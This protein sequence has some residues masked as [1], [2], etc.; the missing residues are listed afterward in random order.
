MEEFCYSHSFL[1]LTILADPGHSQDSRC[2]TWNCL[3]SWYVLSRRL[4][5]VGKLLDAYFTRKVNRFLHICFLVALCQCQCLLTLVMYEK[6]FKS[7]F[8]KAI[9]NYSGIDR[10]PSLNPHLLLQGSQISEGSIFDWDAYW[11]KMMRSIFKLTVLEAEKVCFFKVFTIGCF[12]FWC[13]PLSPIVFPEIIKQFPNM[14][15]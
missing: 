3:F 12:Y 6:I 9:I 8:S 14:F 2:V 4:S 10:S 15:P 13:D 5:I 1:H 11:S 7:H